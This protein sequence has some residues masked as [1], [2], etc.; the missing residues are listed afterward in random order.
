MANDIGQDKK[1]PSPTQVGEGF[2]KVD[3]GGRYYNINAQVDTIQALLAT[4]PDPGVPTPPPAGRVAARRAHQLQR[5]LT[6][7]DRG[8]IIAAYEAG[9]SD[10]H[11]AVEWQL[12]KASVL[13]ILRTGGA[14]I[15]EQRRLSDDEVNY[16]ITRYHDGESL[17]RIGEHLGVAHTTIRTALERRGVPRRDTHGQPR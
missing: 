12:A 2:F 7:A 11:L 17:Q 15:R 4:L 5:R 3:V 10:K 9:S 16:A 8:A 6:D 14:N 13:T 1:K